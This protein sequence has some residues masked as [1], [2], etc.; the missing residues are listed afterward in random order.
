MFAKLMAN[1]LV[2]GAAGFIG[3]HTVKALIKRGDKVI[4]VD[5]L[6]PYYDV[7]LKKARLN[8]IRN[9]IKFYKLDIAEKE[10]LKKVFNNNKIDKICHLGAQAGVRHSLKNPF[11]YERTNI[12]GTLN[13]FEL[14]K[15]FKIKDIIYAS[16]S[17]VYGG[18]KKVP[19][20]EK[21]NVD[22]PVSLYAATKRAN[23]LMAYTYHNLYGF[24]CTGLRYF[25]VYGPFGRPDMALFKFTKNII[26]NKPIEV[27]NYG[28]MK[29]DFTFITD[30]VK[31]TI[32]A[33][34]K[35][36]AYE[37]F[38]LGN[39]KS[40]KLTYFIECIEKAVGKKAEKKLL[41][42]QPGDVTL[43]YAD[44]RKAKKKL[45]Y[46]PNVKIEEGVKKFVKWYK[47]YYKIK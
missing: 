5:N 43:T 8:K 26:E 34:D 31:G 39:A 27:Y 47:D 3:F 7:N 40:V 36:Y 12:L 6:S 45:G 15:E 1:I 18:N 35:A 2:T 4:A 19:F 25:T 23:E 21:D 42:M 30:I 33:I 16:S 32:S 24:N 11:E 10:K 20:S 17:S 14:M 38:N 13:I 22:K 44:I 46:N 37:I 29:R 28:N 9:K 41:P